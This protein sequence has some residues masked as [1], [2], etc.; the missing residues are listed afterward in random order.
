MPL[1]SQKTSAT[2]TIQ[3]LLNTYDH[4]PPIILDPIHVASHMM[5]VSS[6]IMVQVAGG[7]EEVFSRGDLLS[8]TEVFLGGMALAGQDERLRHHAEQTSA[9]SIFS[10][11]P[12]F[13][14][15]HLLSDSA[16]R[17]WVIVWSVADGIHVH[18]PSTREVIAACRLT[19]AWEWVPLV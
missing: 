6:Q 12:Q 18:Q 1:I 17:T 3:D 5:Y 13:C 10:A 16:R 14:D 11:F 7:G 4:H 9:P 2:G 19:P 15:K 8:E